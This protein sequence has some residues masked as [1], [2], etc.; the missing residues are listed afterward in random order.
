M[1]LKFFFVRLYFLNAGKIDSF[2]SWECENGLKLAW[3]LLIFIFNIMDIN[4]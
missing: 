4:M 3:K 2:R 1:I